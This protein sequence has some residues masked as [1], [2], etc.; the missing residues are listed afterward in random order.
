MATGEDT[1]EAPTIFEEEVGSPRLAVGMGSSEED[2]PLRA[3]ALIAGV[4]ILLMAVLAGIANFGGI[5]RLVTKDDA[6]KTGQHILA[7]QGAFRFALVALVVV[8]ILDVMSLGHSSD[9]SNRCTKAF[10]GSRRGSGSSMQG[11]SR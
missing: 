7:S 9:S 1:V 3:S 8:A 5:E 2:R 10:P 11:S 6:T 4:G